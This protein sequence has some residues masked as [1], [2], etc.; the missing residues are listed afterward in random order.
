MCIDIVFISLMPNDVKHYFHELF[1]PSVPLVLWNVCSH[2]LFTFNLPFCWV[3]RHF[4]NSFL[5]KNPVFNMWHFFKGTDV[6]LT[7]LVLLRVTLNEYKL[8]FLSFN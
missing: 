5:V 2:L 6:S 8:C 1:W 4:E 3:M 7:G